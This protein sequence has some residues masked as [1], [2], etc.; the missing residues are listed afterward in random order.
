MDHNLC[1]TRSNVLK[2][3]EDI[4]C[5]RCITVVN[6]TLGHVFSKIYI[7]V[8]SIIEYFAAGATYAGGEFAGVLKI[9]VV[10]NDISVRLSTL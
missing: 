5:S 1:S 10:N 8:S 7:T 9:Q 4:S 3:F 6:D 2:I